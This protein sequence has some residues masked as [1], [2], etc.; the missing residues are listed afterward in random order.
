[1][2]K[3]NLLLLA[4]LMVMYVFTFTGCQKE[5]DGKTE[6]GNIPDLKSMPT[7]GT[8]SSQYSDSPAGEDISKAVDNNTA[9]KYLTFHSTVWLQWKESS[10]STL[11]KYSITSANDVPGRDPKAWTLYGSNNGTSW[12]AVNSQT[13]QAF[14]ARFQK[15]EYTLTGMASYLYYKLDITANNGATITQLS[16]WELVGTTCTPSTIVPYLSVNAGAWQQVSTASVAAGGSISLGPQPLD[17]TWSWAGP[18]GFTSTLREIAITNIQANQGGNYVATYTNLTGCSSSVT[19]A[20]SVGTTNVVT[21]YQDCDYGGYA[22]GL[23]VG[24]YTL[25]ALQAKGITDNDIS[26]LKIT[27]GIK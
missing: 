21:V 4:I 7:G 25:A 18:N 13:N 11:T 5:Q 10:P 23:A 16:E 27:S 24:S 8:I 6:S 15:K 22:I 9:T 1:M 3:I 19:F 2:K 20:I 12:T 14:S 26:S 17:G